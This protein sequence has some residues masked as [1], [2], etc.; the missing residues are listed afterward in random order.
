MASN[1]VR[2]GI[3]AAATIGALAIELAL[4]PMIF[5]VPFLVFV[6]AVGLVTTFAGRGP[7]IATVILS[8]VLGNVFFH[9]PFG[10]LSYNLPTAVSTAFFLLLGG[11]I[12]W[13]VGRYRQLVER[14]RR[15]AAQRRMLADATAEL[16]RSLDFE[17]TLTAVAWLAVPRIAD[18]CSVDLVHDGTRRM[19]ALAHRD[20]AKIALA[21]DLLNRYPPDESVGV[22][23]VIATGK[24]MFSPRITEADL[25][26]AAR[27]ETH[28]SL[29]KTLGFRSYICMPIRRGSELIGALS[30]ATAES[31]RHYTTDDLEFIRQLSNRAAIAIER[32]ELFS[33]AQQHRARAEQASRAKDEF[34][35][36][37]GHELRNPLA[38]IKLAVEMM[39][40]KDTQVFFKERAVIER[41]VRQLGR[42]VDD[43]LDVTRIVR[44]R[45]ELHNQPIELADLV[46]SAVETTDALIEERRH[47]LSVNVPKGLWVFADE[48]RM[49]QVIA[50][51]LAN[52]A[53]YTEPGGRILVSAER[54][55]QQI[56]LRVHDNGVGIA[57]DVLPHIFDMFVQESQGIDRGRGGLGLGLAIV[58][59]L[60]HLHAGEVTAFSEGPGKGSE[61]IVR[62]PAY[63]REVVAAA[64]THEAERPID[65]RPV[66]VVDDNRDALDLLAD[67]L[68]RRGIPT[69]RAYDGPSALAIATSMHPRIALL[70]IGL[71]VMDGYELARRLHELDHSMQLV[72][73][74]GYSQPGDVERTQRAGFVKHM[75][76]PVSLDQIQSTVQQLVVTNPSSA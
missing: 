68:E 28:F 62:L 39:A 52:A 60:V 71:P 23:Y 47:Y 35:A 19:L 48:T 34:L 10:E 73:V 18:W 7:G 2:Y 30:V 55:H 20:P 24:P 25:A 61:F 75:V 6:L 56:V 41:Q 46:R 16:E 8:A 58:R 59:N 17:S 50:N 64:Q 27:D 69:I 14:L 54:E 15:D 33:E 51:L 70:D 44:G 32:A 29:M 31:G 67:G 9:V 72:A 5:H 49:V 57:P 43:L 74:T 45:I 53:K 1:L 37:L 65:G 13:L 3:A 22:G 66:L 76:K 40:E 26:A 21:K 11:V 36:I 4:Q 38:P 12:V 42:L 63:E